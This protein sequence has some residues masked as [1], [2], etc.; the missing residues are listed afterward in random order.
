MEE[1]ATDQMHAIA[2]KLTL[3][4]I[5]VKHQFV[6][7]FAKT[8]EIVLHQILATALEPLDGLEINVN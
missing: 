7:Q 4:E 3:L 6:I 8:V 1:I 2:L 5:S